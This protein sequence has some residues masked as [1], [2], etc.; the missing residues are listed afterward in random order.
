MVGCQ[1]LPVEKR[2]MGVLLASDGLA[3][4]AMTLMVVDRLRVGGYVHVL[5]SALIW[6][7]HMP[8]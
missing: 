8:P 3:D 2:N 7:S 5:A 1:I 6:T 4:V